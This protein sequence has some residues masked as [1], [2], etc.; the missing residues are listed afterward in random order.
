MP[1]PISTLGAAH[2][3][4]SLVPATVGLY[5]FARYRR[6]DAATR[7]GR[8]YLG[9]LLLAVLTSF[10]LSSSG[11]FNAGHALGILALLSAA[12]ALLISRN[13]SLPRAQPYLS[14]LGYSFS[15]FLMWVPG[16][17]ETL[18]RLPLGHP[19]ADGPQSPLVRGA[20][21]AWLGVFL[22]G[23]AAQL[24]WIRSQSRATRRR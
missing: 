17:A 12:G 6:I 20:L 4:I 18:T 15:F 2:T 8:I 5:S 11:S 19:L 7:S 10:G 21:A 14:Q 16:I 1:H 9:G 22:L 23:S 13:S 3:L 24:L